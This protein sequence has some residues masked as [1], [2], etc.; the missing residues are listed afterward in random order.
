MGSIKDS[1]AISIAF[2]AVPP[3]PI[4]SMPGGHHPAP[5]EGTCSTTQS[6]TLALGERLANLVLFS[7]PPPLAATVIST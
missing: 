7:D 5:M 6:A 3:M 1:L 4:P 2:S